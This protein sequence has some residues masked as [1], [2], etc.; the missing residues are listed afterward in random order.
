MNRIALLAAGCAALALAAC[1]HPDAKRQQEARALKVVSKLECPDKQGDLTRVS[2]AADGQSCVYSAKGAEVVLQVLKLD[3]AEPASVLD[4]IEAELKALMPADPAKVA[5]ADTP[6]GENVDIRL[7]G[8]SIKADD[9]GANIDVAGAT[10]NADDS[11]AQVR[12]ERNVR[13]DGKTV[14]KESRRRRVKDDSVTARYILASETSS[15]EWSVVGYEARGP[16][17][18]PL[19]VATVKAKDTSGENDVFSDV[20]RLI[21]HNVGGRAI[22]S[23]FPIR[24]D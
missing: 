18:G 13:V 23:G 14:E 6:K 22:E 8:I 20:T 7:P 1:D 17:G 2:A 10:I 5:A 4:P 3:G 12:V 16:K 15:S 11:G 24:V 19:V 21:R 9:A